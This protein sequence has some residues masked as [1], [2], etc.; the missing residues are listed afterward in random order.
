MKHKKLIIFCS[1]IGAIILCILLCFT[2]FRVHSVELNFKNNSSIY[3][4]QESKQ[5]VINSGGFSFKKP[6]FAVNKKQITKNL[7]KQKV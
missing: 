5:N 4:T 7:E 3:L 1:I 2:L 6:I